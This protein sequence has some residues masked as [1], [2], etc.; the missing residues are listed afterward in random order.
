VKGLQSVASKE[1][2]RV[3]REIRSSGLV[4][5]LEICND[6]ALWLCGVE[7]A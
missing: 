1:A 7:E 3:F 2:Y 6:R 4:R 5:F